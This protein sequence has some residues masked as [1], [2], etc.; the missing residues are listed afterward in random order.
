[1]TR[2]LEITP[3]S[4]VIGAE[5]HGIDLAAPLAD[6]TIDVVRQ[7]FNEHQ[8]LFFRDQSLTPEQQVAFGRRFGELGTHPYVDANPAYPEVIDI[9]TEPDDRVNFGGGWHSDVTFLAE[10]DLGSILY[11]VELPPFGG[12]TLFSSQL[13]AYDALSGTMRSLLDGLVGI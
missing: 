3:V 5:V 4:G 8:V 9:V 13:A 11:A 2:L 7:A 1:M 10:P 6:E 12:D